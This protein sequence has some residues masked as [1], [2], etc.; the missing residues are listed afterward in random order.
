MVCGA[1]LGGGAADGAAGIDEVGGVERCAA[2]LALVAVG[3]GVM[4]VGALAGHI[5]VGEELLGLWVVELL[6]G[7]LYKFTLVVEMTEKFR[8]RLVM[9]FR[10]GA[11]IYVERNAQTLERLLDELMVAVNDI[12]R[13]NTFGAGLESDGH[14]VLV[15][16]ADKQ[17][18]P[19]VKTHVARIDVG[20]HIDACEMADMH[21]AV[22]IRQCRCY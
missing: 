7:L 9:N 1:Q 4:A 3:F 18:L 19:S 5:A 16:A 6:G 8:R 14:T 17:H 22:G 11:R 21:R 20:R 15:A 12:L 2:G 10:S 13:G